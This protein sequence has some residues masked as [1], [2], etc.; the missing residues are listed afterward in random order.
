MSFFDRFKLSSSD[1]DSMTGII[2][3]VA[4]CQQRNEE[5]NIGALQDSLFRLYR[6][7]SHTGGS[8]YVLNYPQKL[9]LGECF[10]L[11]LKYDWEG[12]P[13]IREVW[14]ENAFYCFTEDIQ[15]NIESKKGNLASMLDMFLLLQEAE[16][17]LY[18]SIN[19]VLSRTRYN[20]AFS[21]TFSSK[22]YSLGAKYLIRGFKFYTTVFL[23][24]L[25]QKY[26]IISAGLKPAF[27]SASKDR[28]F[29]LN[30]LR[31]INQKMLFVYLY[32]KS[33]LENH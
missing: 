26:N 11:M 6:N 20:R 21:A 19:D 15:Y 14:A 12:N 28:D 2:S 10:Y 13:I 3:L 24:P 8:K 25:D 33:L 17:S 1:R 5:Q 23:F 18:T 4:E 22:D 31:C 9:D 30:D 32:I 16:E 27:I 7:L 29:N